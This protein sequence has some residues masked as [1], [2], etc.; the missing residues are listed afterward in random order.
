MSNWSLYLVR[1]N[2]GDLYTGIATDVERRFREHQSGTGK[3]AKCLRGKGPLQLAFE[4]QLGTR[5][6]ASKAEYALKRWSKDKKE[7]LIQSQFEVQELLRSLDLHDQ[8]PASEGMR[9]ER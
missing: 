4:V 2:S 8:L 5:S 1:M 7:D 3:G 6:L 9:T